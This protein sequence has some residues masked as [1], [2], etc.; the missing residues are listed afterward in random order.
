MTSLRFLP[1]WSIS[2]SAS[3][4]VKQ[5]PSRPIVRLLHSWAR[6]QAMSSWAWLILLAESSWWWPALSRTRRARSR[7]R[8]ARSRTRRAQSNRTRRARLNRTRRERSRHTHLGKE[9]VIA[10]ADGQRRYAFQKNFGWVDRWKCRVAFTLHFHVQL[11]FLI[12]TFEFFLSRQ[13]FPYDFCTYKYKIPCKFAVCCAKNGPQKKKMHIS[14]SHFSKVF[15]ALDREQGQGARASLAVIA[16][17]S[18]HSPRPHLTEILDPPLMGVCVSKWKKK[19]PDEWQA[20]QA[21]IASAMKRKVQ[22]RKRPIS[23]VESLSSWQEKKRET[24]Y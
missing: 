15:Y 9:V 2:G 21:K 8:R 11:Y 24:I 10:K 20:L 6:P 18:Q 14:S 17:R 4:P 12:M 3:G 22:N 19:V 23:S 13:I 16:V 5:L 7:T 1:T